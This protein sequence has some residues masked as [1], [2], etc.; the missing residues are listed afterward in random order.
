MKM[1]TPVESKLLCDTLEVLNA[2]VDGYT[3]LRAMCGEE[4]SEKNYYEGVL[5]GLSIS[6][7]VLNDSVSK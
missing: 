4:D 6:V 5:Y 7:R 3:A 2:A 1:A